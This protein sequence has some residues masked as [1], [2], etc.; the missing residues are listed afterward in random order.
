MDINAINANVMKLN[1]YIEATSRSYVEAR[2]QRDSLLGKIAK[3]T[4]DV[5]IL[6]DTRE[7]FKILETNYLRQI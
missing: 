4:R 3:D 5:A 1:N 7:V 2:M 6:E